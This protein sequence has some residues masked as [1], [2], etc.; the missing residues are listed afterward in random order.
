MTAH[1]AWEE[2][3][4]SETVIVAQTRPSTSP[5]R[6]FLPESA[7]AGLMLAIAGTIGVLI[8]VAAFLGLRDDDSPGPGGSLARRRRAAAPDDAGA[9]TTPAAAGSD[10]TLRDL[11]GMPVARARLV[12]EQDGLRA[13]VRRVDADR[14]EAR[15]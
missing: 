4:T 13:L 8:A 15:S 3:S 10:V 7:G 5:A 2:P 14:P 1:T 9:A 11:E 6:R 12:L